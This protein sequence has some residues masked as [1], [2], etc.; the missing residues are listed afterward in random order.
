MAMNVRTLKSG[1]TT[2][3]QSKFFKGMRT[4]SHAGRIETDTSYT[5]MVRGHK[6]GL[7]A[8]LTD[9]RITPHDVTWLTKLFGKSNASLLTRHHNIH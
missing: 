6:D 3:E 9:F 2:E 7:G 8:V 1:T 5:P 4:P